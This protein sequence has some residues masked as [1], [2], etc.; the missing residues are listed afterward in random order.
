[1]GKYKQSNREKRKIILMWLTTASK[2]A[3]GNILF[4]PMK[5]GGE[6]TQYRNLG[7]QIVVEMEAAFAKSVFHG[8]SIYGTNKRGMP[9]LAIEK[10]SRITNIAFIVDKNKKERSLQLLVKS[11]H[12][13][14]AQIMMMLS[15][16]YTKDEIKKA[17]GAS[18]TPEELKL[19][20]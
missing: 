17:L 5:H 9:Y 11:R 13:R 4:V 20:K 14:K 18:I 12:T 10:C 1:M 7:K 16:G 2:L 6:R 19:L 15:E 8:L 3:P